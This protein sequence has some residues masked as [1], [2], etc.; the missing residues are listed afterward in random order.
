[1]LRWLHWLIFLDISKAF[2]LKSVVGKG[3]SHY[4]RGQTNVVL[5]LGQRRWR[6]F[7]IKPTLVQ[8]LMFADIRLMWTIYTPS[9]PTNIARSNVDIPAIFKNWIGN[10]NH[11]EYIFY[12]PP[13]RRC[14]KSN[15]PPPPTP[16]KKSK[17]SR[18]HFNRLKSR[19]LP[20]NLYNNWMTAV[21]CWFRHVRGWTNLRLVGSVI[22][23]LDPSTCS[24]IF[25]KFNKTI[26]NCSIP[27]F[28]NNIYIFSLW[29]ITG[30]I[31]SLKNVPLITRWK[32]LNWHVKFG[33]RVHKQQA[34]IL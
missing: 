5:M 15:D 9:G 29:E 11:F 2:V 30:I 13:P 22:Q 18:G 12:L 17:S 10:F 19:I 4:A 33:N 1:M 14:S 24:T 28:E 7:N 8:R 23:D 31:F 6:W 34:T 26:S 25:I 32:I 27:F 16:I 21:I 3:M 20:P